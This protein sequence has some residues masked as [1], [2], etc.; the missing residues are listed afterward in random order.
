MEQKTQYLTWRLLDESGVPAELCEEMVWAM[1]A[2]MDKD[3]QHLKHE[4]HEQNLDNI[5]YASWLRGME[6]WIIS[7]FSPWV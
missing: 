7:L 2:K 1:T 5:L 6:T 4:K 3:L